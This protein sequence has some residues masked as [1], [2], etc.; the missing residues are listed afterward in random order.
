MG[1]SD[2]TAETALAV[3]RQTF[4]E[5]GFPSSITLDRDTRWVGSPQ[6]SDFPAALVRFCHC[7]GVAVLIFDPHHP[8][9]NGFVERYH[10]TLNQAVLKLSLPTTLATS[11]HTPQPFAS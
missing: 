8:Q 1:S 2:F 5:H 3:V 6:G 11:P 7:L 4:A 9:Q 10:L